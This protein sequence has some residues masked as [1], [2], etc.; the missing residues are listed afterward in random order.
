MMLPLA[1]GVRDVLESAFETRLVCHD[2]WI[3]PHLK[4]GA[5]GAGTAVA[6][7][8]NQW[9]DALS[10]AGNRGHYPRE[11]AAAPI[12]DEIQRCGIKPL[13]F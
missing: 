11:R 3:L 5:K 13:R 7:G 9:L 2:E 1:A 10:F 12:F 4:L 8:D 6:R